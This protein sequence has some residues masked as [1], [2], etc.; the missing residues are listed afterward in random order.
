MTQTQSRSATQTS[1]LARVL[2]VTRKVQADLLAIVD[3]YGPYSEDYAIKLIS[4]LRVFLDEEVVQR[5][6]FYWTKPGSNEVLYAY[7]YT[8]VG[9]DALADDRSGGI[10]YRAELEGA[11]FYVRVSY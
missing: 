1:S 2:Y 3:T 5:V 4:D 9:G 6:I 10:G 8:A 7:S 11:P